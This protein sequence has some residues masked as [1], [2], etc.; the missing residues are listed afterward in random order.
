MRHS[1]QQGLE[2]RGKILAVLPGT[3]KQVSE[4]VGIPYS[5]AHYYLNQMVM[6]DVVSKSDMIY[7]K[8]VELS[9][10]SMYVTRQRDSRLDAIRHSGASGKQHRNLIKSHLPGTVSE[11][12]AKTGIPPSSVYAH[13]LTMLFNKHIKR[14]K[15]KGRYVYKIGG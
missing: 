11:L 12:S 3:V 8:G 1:R 14:R 4:L 7:S 15:S 5:S 6:C 2:L 9:P 13:L 10:D